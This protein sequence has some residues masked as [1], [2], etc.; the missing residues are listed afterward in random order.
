MPT[1]IPVDR[2]LEITRAERRSDE[3]A[4]PKVPAKIVG[5][6][7]KRVRVIGRGLGQVI[8][9]EGY[10]R[11]R[12]DDGTVVEVHVSKLLPTTAA[13][14]SEPSRKPA[15]EGCSLC[16]D[17]FR[18]S[19]APNP[20]APCDCAAGR[21]VQARRDAEVLAEG[22]PRQDTAFDRIRRESIARELAKGGKP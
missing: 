7:G 21:A 19:W 9:G 12:L 10:V 17:G 18:H 6:D 1:E 16:T 13:F 4:A 22:P 11:V 8:D 14:G 3:P 15:P 2:F 20:D 5:S